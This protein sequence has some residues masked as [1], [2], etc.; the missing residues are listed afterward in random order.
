M[1]EREFSPGRLEAISD[2]VIAVVITIMVL[3]LHAPA[4]ADP[5]ALLAMWPKF[6]SYFISF[7]FDGAYWVN[8][9]YLFSHMRA[10]DDAVLWTNMLQ[11]MLVSLI[12]FGTAYMGETRFAKFPTAID[13]SI[14]L[15]CGPGYWALRVAISRHIRD[16]KELEVFNQGRAQ[17][18][19]LIAVAAYAA[20][21]AVAFVEPLLAMA[22][23]VAV[24]IMY[25]T[26]YARPE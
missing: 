10:V 16:P 13:A 12:P 7:A 14:M 4:S 6:L 24:S 1:A 21:I 9:R 8:H 22:I 11:L 23:N 15:G 19:S 3:E 20:S 17:A 25:M 26:P 18:I 5:A 2:G